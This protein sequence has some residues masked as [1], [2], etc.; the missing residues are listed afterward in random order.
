MYILSE[1]KKLPKGHEQVL[2]EQLSNVATKDSIA[3]VRVA[4]INYLA[5]NYTD[6]DLL[7]LYKNALNDSS[8]TILSAALA[9]I[10]YAD[11]TLGLLL[12]KQHENEKNK[13]VLTGIAGIYA[14]YGNA[15]NNEF[16][17]N[18]MDKI[19]AYPKSNFIKYYGVYL[20]R[21]T[22]ENIV[23]KG[24][25][26]LKKVIEKDSANKWAVSSA[27]KVIAELEVNTIKKEEQK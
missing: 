4:A 10:T 18:S 25:E 13:D 22:D 26:T 8:Y 7:T 5:A 24:K 6:K 17:I 23:N 12:A 20:K 1:L 21:M 27:K 2:K 19:T 9:A 16:Y 14:L 15:Q 3:T 11:S